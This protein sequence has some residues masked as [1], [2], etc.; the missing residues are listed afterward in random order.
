MIGKKRDVS[1]VEVS[2]T[3]TPQKISRL[4][5][6]NDAL[7]TPSP[8]PR[9]TSEPLATPTPSVRL[10]RGDEAESSQ[11]W[12]LRGVDECDIQASGLRGPHED[13]DYIALQILDVDSRSTAGRAG[14]Q[15]QDVIVT[16]NGIMSATPL[17]DCIS[18]ALK[19]DELSKV[20]M[21]DFCTDAVNDR[22]DM[23]VYR[24]LVDSSQWLHYSFDL[25]SAMSQENSF[26]VYMRP[27]IVR[28][29][30]YDESFQN[31]ASP[32]TDCEDGEL[33]AESQSTCAQQP[34]Y[35]GRETED[36]S[37]M[38]KIWTYSDTDD[39]RADAKGIYG[40]Q[41]LTDIDSGAM[42]VDNRIGN[43]EDKVL[44]KFFRSART[45]EY[46]G[47]MESSRH[48][49]VAFLCEEAAEFVLE[50]DTARDPP[51]ASVIEAPPRRV[52]CNTQ[53]EECRRDD[54][55][56]DSI[57]NDMSAGGEPDGGLR[58]LRSSIPQLSTSQIEGVTLR[59][60]LLHVLFAD[61]E[62]MTREFTPI[63]HRLPASPTIEELLCEYGCSRHI[64]MNTVDY[65]ALTSF[66]DLFNIA[67]KSSLLYTQEFEQ[68]GLME[69]WGK[70]PSQAYGA[71][72]LLR[73]LYDMPRL[74]ND[75]L[76]D[77]GSSPD[78]V[79]DLRRIA[80]DIIT[81]LDDNATRLFPPTH[82][83]CYASRDEVLSQMHHRTATLSALYI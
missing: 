82:V 53:D 63:L 8:S 36:V 78:E 23:L 2:G 12:Y 68:F 71:I 75:L 14:L 79:A 77:L 30:S 58:G 59:Y 33:D 10:H 26:G 54:N 64:H 67:L 73:M 17:N 45:G 69:I 41:A 20:S 40:R 7:L 28:L 48:K 32:P 70:Q 25:S 31:V 61:C 66:R 38:G 6:A 47:F 9:G 18:R 37:D 34:R 11:I 55:N 65:A 27:T 74:Q 39:L 57:N 56:N 49:A 51:S 42:E 15:P 19:M 83:Q 21:Q 1:D 76:P 44:S 50:Q 72:H 35:Y 52:M 24:P 16:I 80:D 29:K 60:N 5:N 13:V 22:C 46:V 62:V 3:S 4:D 43:T 81:W